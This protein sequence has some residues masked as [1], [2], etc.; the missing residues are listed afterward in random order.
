MVLTVHVSL[1]HAEG[2]SWISS[3]G[4][5][6]IW[7]GNVC[8]AD[9]SQQ[10]FDPYSFTHI[11]HGFVYCGLTAWLFPRLAPAWR[12][13][14]AVA[15]EALWEVAENSNFI[16]QRYRAGTASLGYEG[17]TI[18]NSLGDILSAIVGFMIARRLGFR[19]SLAAFLIL[20]IVLIV[21]IKDSLILEIVMLV[22]PLEAI[23]A[24]QLCH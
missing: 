8:S 11:L 19:R 13:W 6:L 5:F 23:K 18:V 16:I 22:H 17:D 7:S 3:S 4:R 9:N 10:F 12:L 21:W 15:I 2:R 24:W 14:L 1:L 20:E